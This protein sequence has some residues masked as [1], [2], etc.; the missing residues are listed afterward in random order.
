MSNTSII[1]I[2]VFA[3]VVLSMAIFLWSFDK[4]FDLTDGGYYVLRYQQNQPIEPSNYLFDHVLVKAIIPPSMRSIESLRYLGLLLNII[5]T[6]LFAYAISKF[7]KKIHGHKINLASLILM[8]LAGF[9]LSYAGTPSDLSYNSLNQFF[10]IS[11]VAFLILSFLEEGFLSLALVSLTGVVCSFQYL[12]KPTSGFLMSLIGGLVLLLSGK[13]RWYRILFFWGS[14]LI[15]LLLLSILLKPNFIVYYYNAYHNVIAGNSHSLRMLINSIINAVLLN[16]EVF[17]LSLIIATV[18][19]LSYLIRNQKVLSRICWWAGIS[20]IMLIYG[21]QVMHHMRGKMV[22][23]AF[24]I[25]TIILMFMSWLLQYVKPHYCKSYIGFALKPYYRYIPLFLLLYI[26]PYIG[27]F[28]SDNSLDWGAKFY[29]T[30]FMGLIV[31]LMPFQRQKLIKAALI[32][33]SFYLITIGL[34]QYVQ[35]PYRSSPLYTQ[36]EKYKGIKYNPEK[37]VFLKKTEAILAKHRFN[38]NQGMI[39][40]YHEPGLV[41]LMGT[42]HPGG[43]LWSEPF[44]RGYFENLKRSTLTYKPVIFAFGNEPGKEFQT[45]FKRA[46]GLDFQKDYRIIETY[47]SYDGITPVYIYFPYSSEMPL[48]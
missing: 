16:I 41:Y 48:L 29:N 7:Y 9:V 8:M 12:T 26:I 10:L 3:A 35:F 39:V 36:T 22:Y 5:S 17:E 27:A 2:F 14:S 44:Q 37:Y 31:L 25:M 4:G 38:R 43:I 46:T 6:A 11:A 34:F 28:G 1:Y 23:S 13:P 32:C 47:K 19:W 24:L 20:L 45:S 21:V 18:F 40:A 30:S 42:F 15:A 33:F